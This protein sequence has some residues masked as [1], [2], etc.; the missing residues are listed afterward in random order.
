[1]QPSSHLLFVPTAKRDLILER[2]GPP[3]APGDELELPDVEGPLMVTQVGRSPYPGQRVARAF[4]LP[5]S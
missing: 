4:L 1:M 3:P 5:L 2:D